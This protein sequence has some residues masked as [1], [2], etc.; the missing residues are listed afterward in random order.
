MVPFY[1]WEIDKNNFAYSMTRVY[2]WS[3][4]EKE[5]WTYYDE[6]GNQVEKK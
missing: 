4:Q 1:I 5:N 2:N 6:T 3:I